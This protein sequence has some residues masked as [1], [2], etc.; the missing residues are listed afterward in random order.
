M[1]EKEQLLHE[2][3]KNMEL[4]RKLT[5][6]L[7]RSNKL[8]K[9]KIK[10]AINE[11]DQSINRIQN[12][13]KKFDTNDMREVGLQHGID[14][15]G[16]QIQSIT[17]MMSSVAGSVM[18]PTGGIFGSGRAGISLAD[19]GKQQLPAMPLII[20]GIVLVVLMLTGKRR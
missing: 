7:A 10:K 11:C 20:A 3:S 14:T 15:R 9:R 18:S 6:E 17:T 1:T 2:L 19:K 4:K 8:F 12:L 5:E 13:L 16:N